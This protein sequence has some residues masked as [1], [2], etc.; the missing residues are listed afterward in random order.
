MTHVKD[1]ITDDSTRFLPYTPRHKRIPRSLGSG[2][3][4]KNETLRG[5]DGKIWRKGPSLLGESFASRR[6]RNRMPK[7]A[8][9][10]EHQKIWNVLVDRAINGLKNFSW[11]TEQPKL[12]MDIGCATVAKQNQREPTSSL[13]PVAAVGKMSTSYTSSRNGDTSHNGLLNGSSPSLATTNQTAGLSPVIRK[14]LMG[15][16]GFANLPNQ[17]HR[18]SVRKGFQFTAMVVG[19]SGLGKSTLINTLF[20]T[21]LYPPKEP[22]PPA[23][24]RSK[25]VA[26][27]S[28]GADIEENGVR[29]HLTVVDTPGFG[30]FVNNDES[31]KPIVENIES[32]F[33]SYLEQENRVNR[34]KVIDNR[35]H[36]CLY[37]IQPTGHS[38]KQIDIEFMRRLHTKVNLIPVIAK[39]D[40]LTEEEVAEF[41]ER[42]L[43]DIA[44]HNIHIFQAPTYENEDEETIAEHEEIAS[45]IPFA[46]VGSDKIVTTPDGRQVRGRVYP[47]GVVEVDNEEHCDFVKL[48]QMLVRTY[49]EELR[50]YTND[51]LYENWRTEKLLS[52]GVAQDSSVFKEIN[53]AARMQEERI[54]HDAKLAKMEAE[55]KM[56]FQQKVQ[57]KEAKLKQSEEELYARHKEMKDALDKQRLDLEEKKRKIEGGRPLTPEKASTGR[58]K[59]F[60]PLISAL[61]VFSNAPDKAALDRANSWLQDFQH[62]PEAWATCNVLLFTPSY[63]AGVKLFAAQTFRTKVTYDLQQV[64]Q[65]TLPELRDSLLSALK[66]YKAGPRNIVTQLCLAIAGIALQMPEWANPVETMV[67]A[68]GKNP[69]TVHLLLQFLVILPEEVNGNS[70]IPITD[71]E[72]RERVDHLLTANSKR[73]VDLL[74]MYSQALGVS[75]EVQVQIFN[76]LRSWIMAGE[77]SSTDL[78]QSPL[79]AFAFEALASHQLFDAAVDVICEL[80]H[81]T[82]EI[83]DNMP[84]IEL[85]VPKVIA[86]KPLLLEH[87]EDPDRIKGYA[88]IFTEAGETY[89]VLL[90]HHAETFFPIVEAIGECSAYSDLDIVPITFPFWMRLAQNI[91]KRSSV[92]PLFLDAY[93]SLMR[94]IIGHL[95]FPPDSEGLTGQEADTFRSFRHVMG[96]TLKDCCFVLRTDNCLLATYDL[97]TAALSRGPEALSWQEI[98]APLFALRSMGAEIDPHDNNAVPKI[99]DLIPLLPDHPRVRYAALLI[100]SRYTEWINMHPDYIPFQLQYISSGF[101]TLDAEVSAAA[102]QALKYLCQDC[103]QHLVDFLPTLHSFLTTSGSKLSQDD[104]RQVYEAI[105][106]VISAIPMERAAESLRAFSLDILSNI[107]TISTQPTTAT[108]EEIGN[109]NNGLE[110]LEIMLHVIRSFGEEL[111]TSCQ[112]TCQQAWL[113]LDAFLSKYGSNYEVTERTT[114]VLRHG[115]TFF[116]KAALPV[117]S[118]VVGRMSVA[119]ENTGYSSYLWIAGKII[120]SF[121][122]G[123][124][125]KLVWVE[126][127]TVEVYETLRE[128]SRVLFEQSTAKV[129]SLLR[130]KSPRDLPDVLEDYVQ[131]LLKLVDKC[132]DIFFQS[133]A[134]PLAFRATMAALTVVHTD[135]VFAALDLFRYILTHNCLENNPSPPPK[136]PSYATAINGVVQKEGY[137]LVGYL[138]AGFISDFPEDSTSTVVSIVRA[139]AFKW[140]HELLT[141]LP[142]ILGQLP[143]T[144]APNE[145]KTRFLNDVTSAIKAKEYDKVKYAILELNRVSRKTRERRQNALGVV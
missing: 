4:M 31:W 132:P 57:E 143:S 89:R 52:M 99:M 114:R 28:I 55:M 136:F 135:V 141:W 26:I 66:M 126:G 145:A 62:S 84:I 36:A 58:K 87:H 107:H 10:A 9:T 106:H 86:L 74:S 130:L 13:S 131:M 100:I 98:E 15:Y 61:D 71:D 43:S 77:V 73:V 91:G 5:I 19:E 120:D 48:R 51:V 39:A 123:D 109:S 134:F 111:P 53:P 3:F 116:G 142:T 41:K 17:V 69:E 112:S 44:H 23:A 64:D 29:L 33:D 1:C 49:M 65:K 97:I 47:W 32:R 117:A 88:R 81:E 94:V 37:F 92:P 138:L 24:E 75:F 12:A 7:S 68:F 67:E 110:N 101:D 54:Q 18:K 113:V 8:K 20:N 60:L 79:F 108:Q 30:D 25:T 35:V 83:D 140:G 90:L 80:I 11:T 85:I 128:A 121:G 14:K 46:V 129:V 40:T 124:E 34:T 122:N 70:R 119:F 144:A 38:L 82:Q 127:E 76:C 137:E 42:I 16:V 103:K 50:E 45:K 96:D 2:A 59:G 104:K 105:A 133:S 63:S 78:T 21:T 93:R 95:H 72:Y 27:E 118:A 139:I 102:G 125:R 22:Q 56:V 6:R 115:I